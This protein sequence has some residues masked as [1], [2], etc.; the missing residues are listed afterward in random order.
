MRDGAYDSR[1]Q[2]VV[3]VAT[4]EDNARAWGLGSAVAH[5]RRE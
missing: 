4:E 3:D 5:T 2:D 1:S